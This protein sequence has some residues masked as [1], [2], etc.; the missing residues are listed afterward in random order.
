MGKSKSIK[1]Q[2]KMNQNFQ[3]YLKT[4]KD[5]LKEKVAEESENFAEKIKAFYDKKSYTVM[6]EGER[7][8]FRQKDEF[9]LDSITD[10]INSVIDAAFSPGE[11]KPSD[12]TNHEYRDTAAQ[13]GKNIVL[14][15]LKIFE[16][17][18]IV[19]FT[20][21]YTAETV[22]PGLTLHMLVV[23]DSF[24]NEHW[25]GNE[26]IIEN[27]I[28]FQLIYSED[29]AKA[30][31]KLALYDKQIQL[32]NTYLNTLNGVERQFMEKIISGGV[33]EAELKLHSSLTLYM[34][35]SITDCIQMLG[36]ITPVQT[37]SYRPYINQIQEILKGNQYTEEGK[38]ALKKLL[39]ME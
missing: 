20:H 18:S 12:M 31:A 19:E 27:Y 34:R 36:G 29:I 25:L 15:S 33:T 16:A 23:T 28:V 35:S 21:S 13:V 38:T 39:N 9:N 30:E 14:N 11:G 3:E 8:D 37:I 22:A 10:V 5:S 24:A 1:D 2:E 6:Q 4:L 17:T 7:W 26:S 32:M